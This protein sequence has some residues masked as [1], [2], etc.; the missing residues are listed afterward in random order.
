MDIRFAAIEREYGSAGTQIGRETAERCGIRCYGREIMEM[1]AGEQQISVEALEDYE[2]KISGSLLYS[3]FV[4]SQSQTGD[5]DLVSGESKLY[6]AE[7]RQIRRLSKAGPAIFVGHCAAK[8]LEQEPGVL[9]VFIRGSQEDKERRIR[10]EYG[11]P[12]EQVGAVSRRFN[13]RR[14][15]YYSFCTGKHWDDFQNYDLVLDSSR[16]GVEGCV[17]VL[18][19]LLMP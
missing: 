13:R 17:K 4:M 19:S 5:P 14:S 3:L 6:V 10:Q 11:I 1:V 9:R 15:N 2:E 8:A 12:P 7:S 16:L 18:C